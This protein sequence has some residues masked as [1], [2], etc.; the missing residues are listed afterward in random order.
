MLRFLKIPS[1][2]VE[3][4]IKDL[5][6]EPGDEVDRSKHI[7][8]VAFVS[9]SEGHSDWHLFDV[10]TDAENYHGLS[11][12]ESRRTSQRSFSL[13][14]NDFDNRAKSAASSKSGVSIKRKRESMKLRNR[15]SF[16]AEDLNVSRFFSDEFDRPNSSPAKTKAKTGA[17]HTDQHH[18]IEDAYF[19]PAPFDMIKTHYPL[20]PEHQ[21]TVYPIGLRQFEKLPVV[22]DIFSSLYLSLK[23]SS[24]DPIVTTQ[25]GEVELTFAYSVSRLLH[26]NVV[27]AHWN[28]TKWHNTGDTCY[29]TKIDQRDKI[30]EVTVFARLPSPGEYRLS[31]DA[32]PILLESPFLVK[33]REAACCKVIWENEGQTSS[34]KPKPHLPILSCT[35]FGPI[36]PQVAKN[37]ALEG[38]SKFGRIMCENGVLELPLICEIQS[39]IDMEYKICAYYYNEKWEE[40]RHIA[41]NLCHL[42]KTR[43]FR[44]KKG[45]RHHEQLKTEEKNVLLAKV[46]FPHAGEFAL[47]IDYFIPIS[48][49]WSNLVNYLVTVQST[50]GDALSKE[51]TFEAVAKTAIAFVIPSFVVTFVPDSEL[52]FQGNILNC[53]QKHVDSVDVE[54]ILEASIQNSN[55]QLD[56]PDDE[57]REGYGGEDHYMAI[58]KMGDND[59][60][61]NA[62][63]FFFELATSTEDEKAKAT[64]TITIESEAIGTQNLE[65]A[66]RK[67]PSAD[68]S[69]ENKNES[70][71]SIK[72]ETP[73]FI[74]E[75]AYS[76]EVNSNQEI[77]SL[78]SHTEEENV[79]SNL[80]NFELAAKTNEKIP[81]EPE[82]DSKEIETPKKLSTVS[83]TVS[84]VGEPESQVQFHASS[85][86]KFESESEESFHK[87]ED[88]TVDVDVGVQRATLDI[89]PMPSRPNTA[90]IEVV[91]VSEPREDPTSSQSE[92]EAKRTVG[93]NSE[94]TSEM[95]I[96]I[97]DSKPM[98]DD[99]PA[100]FDEESI[101]TQ[102]QESQKNQLDIS[103]KSEKSVVTENNISAI[104]MEEV[105]SKK[106]VSEAEED[107]RSSF[108]SEIQSNKS[109]SINGYRNSTG[110]TESNHSNDTVDDRDFTAEV[111]SR[112]SYSVA[113]NKHSI[114]ISDQK[115]S[116]NGNSAPLDS[117]RDSIDSK[118]L[119][120]QVAS[121]S[122]KDEE[123]K[124]DEL[125][126][127]SSN[128]KLKNYFESQLP[129]TINE[130]PKIIKN[131][132]YEDSHAP[133]S[134][135]ES[136]QNSATLKT[137]SKRQSISDSLKS[138]KSNISA[139]TK[140]SKASMEQ[141]LVTSSNIEF[142]HSGQNIQSNENDN[143]PNLTKL[144]PRVYTS[145]DVQLGNE[146]E[147]TSEETEEMNLEN[148]EGDQKATMEL[149]PQPSSPNT[150]SEE[151]VTIEEPIEKVDDQKRAVSPKQDS[152]VDAWV[153]AETGDLEIHQSKREQATNTF[154]E[155]QKVNDE[156]DIL[157]IEERSQTPL[158]MSYYNFRSI[159]PVTG[160]NV[161]KWDFQ[162]C[163]KLEADEGNFKTADV[164]E[165]TISEEFNYAATELQISYVSSETPVR[166]PSPVV[167]EASQH[168]SQSN[169]QISNK[170][171]A[172]NN[173]HVLSHKTSNA[174]AKSDLIEQLNKSESSKKQ[175]TSTHNADKAITP[176]ELKSNFV[177]DENNA[178]ASTQTKTTDSKEQKQQQTN[179]TN[180]QK[181]LQQNEKSTNCGGAEGKIVPT[182]PSQESSKLRRRN[183]RKSVG[184]ASVSSYKS[185]ISDKSTKQATVTPSASKRAP[186]LNKQS[187]QSKISTPT[188][189]SR[190]SSIKTLS[191]KESEKSIGTPTKSSEESISPKGSQ[192]PEAVRVET[193]SRVQSK[194]PVQNTEAVEDLKIATPVLG[195]S[196][197]HTQAD[198]SNNSKDIKHS[199]ARS[200]TPVEK[201][202]ETDRPSE[203]VQAPLSE[204]NDKAHENMAQRQP[205]TSA[206]NTVNQQE[207]ENKSEKSVF[208]EESILNQ[209]AQNLDHDINEN[210]E[211]LLKTKEKRIDGD[212]VVTT[213]ENEE[214]D[215]QNDNRASEDKQQESESEYPNLYE[216]K[217]DE[218]EKSKMGEKSVESEDHKTPVPHMPS[219]LLPTNEKDTNNRNN[220]RRSTI[221]EDDKVLEDIVKTYSEN[222]K[223]KSNGKTTHRSFVS[224]STKPKTLESSARLADYADSRR[225]LYQAETSR[226]SKQD[227]HI[228]TKLKTNTKKKK[229]A[230]D[231]EASENWSS[232]QESGVFQMG[233]FESNFGKPKESERSGTP[234]MIDSAENDDAKIYEIDKD[235]LIDLENTFDQRRHES[236]S[237]E[238][239]L[240]A[241]SIPRRTFHTATIRGTPAN[242]GRPVTESQALLD[243]KE[244]NIL[245]LEELVDTF[246]KAIEIEGSE[247]NGSLKPT[248]QALLTVELENFSM[249]KDTEIIE[250]KSLELPIAVSLEETMQKGRFTKSFRTPWQLE[251]GTSESI[252]V[253]EIPE[254]E[255]AKIIDFNIREQ[256]KPRKASKL[257]KTQDPKIYGKDRRSK[258]FQD[259][260][261]LNVDLREKPE[262]LKRPLGVLSRFRREMK[263]L[264][265]ENEDDTKSKPEKTAEPIN[266]KTSESVDETANRI[267]DDQSEERDQKVNKEKTGK[268]NEEKKNGPLIVKLNRATT[269]RNLYQPNT[270][271]MN[272]SR[273]SIFVDPIG[274][275]PIA[276]EP[277]RHK[278]FNRNLARE[279]KSYR[280]PGSVVKAVLK[281]TFIVLGESP[282]CLD[283]WDVVSG[284]LSRSLY[285]DSLTVRMENFQSDNLSD[286]A[287]ERAQEVL[288]HIDDTDV[289]KI[290]KPVK[291]LLDWVRSIL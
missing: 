144:A 74:E 167:S 283:D 1:I 58:S 234:L 257:V 191:R 76:N 123:D 276:Q 100:Q 235:K 198:L 202:A 29:I 46:E 128:D 211:E 42:Q 166:L 132:N 110:N 281:A 96:E 89:T 93:T 101:N 201:P 83:G 218:D 192:N 256:P 13:S 214:I 139:G 150:A 232:S 266:L 7:W 286:S 55:E 229:A 146:I 277:F 17:L 43:P 78:S 142:F 240:F 179:R 121:E 10:A 288:S 107:H 215:E 246:D 11:Y 231:A 99:Q 278:S 47:S 48:L 203:N 260:K 185:I 233:T 237:S 86:V 241:K 287:K 248:S 222:E 147:Y 162:A 236:D 109:V 52:P 226:R 2:R 119:S 154:Q 206:Q 53:L 199:E 223:I 19:S 212:T 8:N 16:E 200:Q 181:K 263:R 81:N 41:E 195:K 136:E 112:T 148:N 54:N 193:V 82:I 269:K 38:A 262:E 23:G 217:V 75:S 253:T 220:R 244:E 31:L 254:F 219:L 134:I 28:M 40:I 97:F 21:L 187:S 133:E 209:E 106:S 131:V 69:Y 104:D 224:V 189:T 273:G 20:N 120:A 90:T 171:S 169:E 140:K 118:A 265:I 113:S 221:E 84:E 51:A 242:I 163:E 5:M 111:Q 98:Y 271:P 95:S 270:P 251:S 238:K 190:K 141:F 143:K 105:Q 145:S 12:T 50:P 255:T 204:M 25:D 73:P 170:S 291:I 153:I 152:L 264:N 115:V 108:E 186:D 49:K 156:A 180:Q 45:H 207:E 30:A 122:L 157:V 279:L 80:T 182:P 165:N 210:T 261:Y 289:E 268:E 129:D 114:E 39:L 239:I 282:L 164:I 258:R 174:S 68:L 194:T 177:A 102:R 176:P 228:Q 56:L 175:E 3:G 6:F 44:S 138:K 57:K 227:S 160:K 26:F 64:S 34:S 197:E 247:Q 137:D 205:E 63:V 18:L 184:G 208:S 87:T 290:S 94:K 15:T 252:E 243:F 125:T 196:R 124:T 213:V 27:L 85:E 14:S 79:S 158:P 60:S 33:P 249:E 9:D 61:K 259:P 24:G 135:L 168:S 272:K 172:K 32:A 77:D 151:V 267:A 117:R 230:P 250:D 36:L 103:E 285:K 72:L 178:L 225:E 274:K 188:K 65:A 92:G 22:R 284:L 161:E 280:K 116:D 71:A 149:T 130:T 275:D 155:D 67:T 4:Y 62:G 173:D 127:K 37:F 66:A 59:K 159:S 216:T 88:L 70:E 183:S 91:D 126:L 35:G 245:E